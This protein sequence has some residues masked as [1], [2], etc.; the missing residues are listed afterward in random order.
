L[1]GFSEGWD[2]VNCW[3]D[4][5]MGEMSEESVIR[6]MRGMIVVACLLE[7]VV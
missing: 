2:I 1:G 4:Y 7:M 6:P 3:I 5:E